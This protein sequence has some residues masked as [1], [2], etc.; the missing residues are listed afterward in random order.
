MA[1]AGSSNNG[2]VIV[3]G[4][5]CFSFLFVTFLTL[6]AFYIFKG[7]D[8]DDDGSDDESDE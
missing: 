1:A 6:E 7:S 3:L 5:I 4:I 2:V 8:D